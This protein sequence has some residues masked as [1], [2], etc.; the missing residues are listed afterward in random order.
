MVYKSGI[1]PWNWSHWPDLIEQARKNVILNQEMS[2]ILEMPLEFYIISLHMSKEWETR[3][4][5]MWLI[6]IMFIQSSTAVVP[7]V[8]LRHRD[9]CEYLLGQVRSRR[10]PWQYCSDLSTVGNLGHPHLP[11]GVQQPPRGSWR[12]VDAFTILRTAA[13]NTFA[14]GAYF[15]FAQC[16][17]QDEDTVVLPGGHSWTNTRKLSSLLK[18]TC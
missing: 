5:R 3:Q 11:S 4:E 13:T 6:K 16:E 17:L 15:W 2:K 1:F 18:F 9:C 7:K 10:W 14:F 12:L 8:L